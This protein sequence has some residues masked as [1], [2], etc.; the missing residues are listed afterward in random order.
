MYF[1][2]KYSKKITTAERSDRQKWKHSEDKS[3][4]KWKCMCC[5]LLMERLEYVCDCVCVKGRE[6]KGKRERERERERDQMRKKIFAK[7]WEIG[8]RW[9]YA[10]INT[11][12]KSR[13]LLLAYLSMINGLNKRLTL[14]MYLLNPA[15][16]YD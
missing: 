2:N 15:A 16:G 12:S 10:C 5:L 13:Y 7:K 14:Y 9:K 11:H 1:Y 8:F 4:W 3:E 6:L